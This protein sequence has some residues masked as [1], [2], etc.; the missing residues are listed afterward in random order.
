MQEAYILDAV[1]TPRG[2]GKIT[3]S[4][5]EV[6]P[7]DLIATV[8]DAIRQR[9][10]LDTSQVDD[11]I[12]GCVTP[13]GEQGGNIAK[14][15]A[16][17]AGW[18]QSVA[19]VQLNRQCGSA[20]EAINIAA[21]KIRSGWEDLVVAGGVESMSRVPMG[22]D[23]GPLLFD[24]AVNAT[25]N[26]IPQGVSADLLAT[27]EGYS[28]AQLDEYALQSQQRALKAQTAGYFAPSLVPIHDMNGLV[29]LDHDEYLRP[30]TNLDALA[31][32]Q[33]SFAKQGA[34]GFDT[35]AIM[36]YPFLDKIT[37]HHTAGNSSGIVDGAAAVLLGSLEK[38]N[39][40]GITPKAKILSV[41]VTS[42][43]PTL[44]LD[45]NI[46]AAEKALRKANL[47]IQDIDLWEVNE[48]FAGPLLKFKTHFGI[49][50]DA[51]NVN[52][53][54]IA[55]GH[56]LGA[57]GAILLANLV[58]ELERRSLSKGV[59]AMC[60]AGGMGVATIVELV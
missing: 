16:L 50:N 11:L 45:G 6:K 55:L 26:Y 27:L 25:I 60:I 53:G 35:M 13:V 42:A 23:G 56:P 22:S 18:H 43:E 31:K 1:H 10:D 34:L 9:N 15:A 52:G 38:A 33:P 24:P 58:N 59:V 48:A 8:L 44:M 2:R 49:D 5:H 36:R 4:L 46:P 17:Y 47:T 3:G 12:L 28:R 32:L 14:A 19:G 30:N 20:L 29:V 41:A 39:E 57:T 37:H 51:I 40:L 54:V 7:I 21:M